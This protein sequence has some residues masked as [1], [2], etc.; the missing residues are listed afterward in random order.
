M[1]EG[2]SGSTMTDTWRK[3]GEVLKQGG[4]GFRWG[5]GGMGWK[6]LQ[7]TVIEQQ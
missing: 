5:R 3:L 4:C 1:R 7:T 6:K 2:F